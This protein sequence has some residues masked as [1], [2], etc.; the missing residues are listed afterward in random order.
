MVKAPIW[1]DTTYST[2]STNSPLV[3]YIEDEDG[4]EIFRGR[5]YAK[6]MSE[7]L[8]L[9]LNTICENYLKSDIS[10]LFENAVNTVVDT[11]TS[12]T[13]TLYDNGGE[14]LEQYLF[15]KDW[16]YE[17]KS[18]NEDFM[19]SCP[20]NGHYA[21]GMYLFKTYFESNNDSVYNVCWKGVS[22]SDFDDNPLY[23]SKCCGEY[24]LYYQNRYGGW[25]SFL[26]EGKVVRSDK[27]EKYSSTSSYNN[28]T[29]E[30]GKRTYNNR[31]TVSYKMNSG[32]LDD[33]ESEKF[34][35]HLLSSNNI[36]VHNLLTGK[37]SPCVLVD[38]STEYRRKRNDRGLLN[39][40]FTIEESHLQQ[41]I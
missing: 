2:L 1:K 13:F 34:A 37:I 4:N 33:D 14:R 11:G 5:A 22:P 38:G 26:I 27:Y 12:R 24:A 19:M 20:V 15:V 16:S 9:K 25:D 36:Y 40:T 3:Y 7:L 29:L 6:P 17:D 23:S 32:W 21:D 39:Y 30:F 41:N 28:N 8:T 10:N 31:I 35:F 18:Y